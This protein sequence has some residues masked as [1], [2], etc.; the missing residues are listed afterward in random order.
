LD[1]PLSTSRDV[2]RYLAQ[3]SLRMETV[4]RF[5]AS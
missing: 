2:N 1:F 4:P 5:R 3:E